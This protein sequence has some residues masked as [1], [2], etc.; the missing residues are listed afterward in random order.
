VLKSVLF[1]KGF[2]QSAVNTIPA[3]MIAV[4]VQIFNYL[5]TYVIKL[6]TQF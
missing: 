2:P 5:Y 1:M 3:I 6:I 4:V